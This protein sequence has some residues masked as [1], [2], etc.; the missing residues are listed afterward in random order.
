MVKTA[1]ELACIRQA[2][3]IN[4]VAMYDVQRALRPGMRQPDLTGMLLR[5]V[6]ELGATANSIDP[7]WQVLTPYRSDGPYTTNGDI[8][9]PLVTT[10]RQLHEGDVIWNDTGVHYHGYASDFERTW[11]VSDDPRPTARQLGQ[12]HQ[13][14]DVAP[15]IGTDAGPEADQSVVLEPGMILVLEPVVWDDGY[16]GYRGEDIVAVTDEGWVALSDYPHDPT[17]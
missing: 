7:I 5:R 13:W 2:Q 6:F 10:D 12:F 9:F 15:M 11:I 8:A 4:E 3:H 14:C 17:E 1:D 16:A